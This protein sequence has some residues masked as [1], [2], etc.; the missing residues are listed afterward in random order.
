[1]QGLTL[2]EVI[3]VSAGFH[4]NLGTFIAA[5]VI[6]T[7]TGGPVGLGL[8]ISGVVMSEGINNLQDMYKDEFGN[9][10]GG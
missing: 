4:I 2:E 1:M 9:N 6:G 10:P 8:A 7:I 5:V 3:E